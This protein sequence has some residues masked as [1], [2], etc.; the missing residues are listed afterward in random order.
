MRSQMHFSVPGAY[1]SASHE[2]HIHRLGDQ[3]EVLAAGVGS[4]D[5]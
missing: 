4:P 5:H 3:I 2:M 1:G